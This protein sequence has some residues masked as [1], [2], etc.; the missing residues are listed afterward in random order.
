MD[1]PSLS[2]DSDTS[3][4]GLGSYINSLKSRLGLNLCGHDYNIGFRITLCLLYH[5]QKF[6]RFL[7][8]I[9]QVVVYLVVV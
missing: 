3:G 8:N 1:F 6:Q 4:L 9:Y 5:K 2:L 7:K